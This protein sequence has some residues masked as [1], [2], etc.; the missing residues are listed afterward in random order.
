[1]AEELQVAVPADSAEAQAADPTYEIPANPPYST[2][3]RALQVTDP[4]NA[5]TVFNPLLLQM[6]WNT[7]AAY[8]LAG[9]SAPA[10]HNHDAQ[11]DALGAAEE[12]ATLVAKQGETVS[13]VIGDVANLTFELA[14]Q[15]L[16]NTDGMQHVIVDKIEAAADVNIISGRFDSASKKVYI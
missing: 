11:Y 4:A 2:A 14:V 10:E 16:I 9:S 12:V 8:L 6:I 3:L 5:E 15:G 1:M 7:H 13:A